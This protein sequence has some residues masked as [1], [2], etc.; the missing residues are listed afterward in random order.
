MAITLSLTS[1]ELPEE[2]LQDLTQDLCRTINIETDARARLLE[3]P[4]T[5][6]GTRGEPITLGALVL[7]FLTSGTAVALIEIL[8]TYFERSPS[9]EIELQRKDGHKLKISTSHIHPDQ[10]HHT[11]GALQEFFRDSEA[12]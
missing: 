8:K 11:I 1:K 2:I 10:I 6:P 3:K 4:P 7:A 12:P 5:V 9:L